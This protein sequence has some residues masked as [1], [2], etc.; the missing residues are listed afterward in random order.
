MNGSKFFHIPVIS[1]L[2]TSLFLLQGCASSYSITYDSNPQGAALVCGGANKGATPV[3][4]DY[5]IEDYDKKIG[6]FSPEPCGANWIS[7]AHVAYDQRF[8]L[9]KYPNGAAQTVQRPREDAD[10]YARD[11]AFANKLKQQKAK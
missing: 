6:F 8:D 10:G 11:E 2:L 9:T 5:D 7:G 4:I 1:S 3:T